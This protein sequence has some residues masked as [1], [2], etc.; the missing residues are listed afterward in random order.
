MVFIRLNGKKLM[1]HHYQ[2]IKILFAQF[3]S[4][5]LEKIF[6]QEILLL[7]IEHRFSN[8]QFAFIP[9][10]FTGTTNALTVFHLYILNQITSSK[11]YIRVLALDFLKAFDKIS[12]NRLIEVAKLNF[13][14]QV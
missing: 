4:K 2:K 7:P 6:I 13:F 9:H 10:T 3:L 8:N 11:S 12:H 5:V 14:N 1:L